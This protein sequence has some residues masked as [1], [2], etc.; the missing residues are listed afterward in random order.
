M[1]KIGLKIFTTGSKKLYKHQKIARSGHTDHNLLFFLLSFLSIIIMA[2]WTWLS[3]PTWQAWL[4][5]K[6][7]NI[8]WVPSATRL[9]YFLNILDTNF[10]TKVAQIFGNFFDYLEKG[11]F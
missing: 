1:F 3:E 2:C 4:S 10:L 11:H 8:L 6:R 5:E 7:S 9:G